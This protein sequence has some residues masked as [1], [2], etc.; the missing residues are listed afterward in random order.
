MGDSDLDSDSWDNTMSLR[1][2]VDTGVLAAGA[3]ASSDA[4]TDVGA[5]AATD[6]GAFA[7]TDAIACLEFP[8]VFFFRWFFY[9]MSTWIPFVLN[10][11]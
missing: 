1:F 4:A 7:A 6:V 2:L 11:L 3:G 10:H 8:F 9:I 5:F